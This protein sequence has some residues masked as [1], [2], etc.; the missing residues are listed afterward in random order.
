MELMI[1]IYT[2]WKYVANKMRKEPK[3]IILNLPECNRI[4]PNIQK[5]SITNVHV[6]FTIPTEILKISDEIVSAYRSSL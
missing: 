5:M 1:Y 4:I 2:H 3:H 6:D